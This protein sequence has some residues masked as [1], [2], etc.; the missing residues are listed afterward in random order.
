[1]AEGYGGAIYP[2]SQHAECD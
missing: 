1:M 2:S